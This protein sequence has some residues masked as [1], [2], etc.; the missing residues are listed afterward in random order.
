MSSVS[1]VASL[2]PLRKLLPSRDIARFRDVLGGVLT[3]RLMDHQVEGVLWMK[4]MEDSH[5]CGGGLADDMGLG[6]TLQTIVTCIANGVSPT[7]IVCPNALTT[8]WVN[9]FTSKLN[10]PL[11]I[12]VYHGVE[13]RSMDLDDYD[14]VVTTYRTLVV[15]HIKHTTTPSSLINHAWRRVVLDESQNIKNCT[16]KVAHAVF[17]LSSTFRWCL[18]GTPVQNDLEELF[19]TVHFL[20]VEG[21]SRRSVFVD[22]VLFGA[23]LHALV[24]ALFLRRHKERV[25]RLRSKTI[26]EHECPMTDEEYQAY[27]KVEGGSNKLFTKPTSTLAPDGEDGLVDDV[28]PN[29]IP[30][31]NSG[32]GAFAKLTALRTACNDALGA[33]GTL[34]SKQQ[35][36]VDL[37]RAFVGGG[38]KVLV[39]S[40]YLDMI[41]ALRNAFTERDVPCFV[42][43]GASN[44]TKKRDAI[45]ASFKGLDGGAVLIMQT[46]VGSVGLNL[47]QANK[48][49]LV[50]PWWNP[51]VD[52][53]AM[54]R[55]HRIGQQR[56]VTVYKFF[57]PK[58][59]EERIIALQKKK[60]DMVDS[61]WVK[62]SGGNSRRPKLSSK[63]V[64]YL[65]TGSSK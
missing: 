20:R 58:T 14:V 48:V 28:V 49:I 27:K 62:A 19:S 52:D 35:G 42:L 36:V 11:R 53:Q 5:F 37:A 55:A 9:E 21:Y 8:N 7:L 18:S 54:D 57:T 32:A 46:M 50:E 1:S 43:T 44:T 60:R 13:R 64:K 22:K 47:T 33:V 38:E 51:F 65:L 3:V 6:K 30:A 17:A 29:V 59:I 16:T 15:D 31:G 24:N 61:M 2:E 34:S 40:Q 26:I 23:D 39:F 25:L 4:S 41:G 12:G 10:I 63:E 56:E 45:L